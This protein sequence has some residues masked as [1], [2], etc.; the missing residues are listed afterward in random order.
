MKL[1]IS[2]LIALVVIGWSMKDDFTAAA[3]S[4]KNAPARIQCVL[5]GGK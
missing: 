1:A 4:I 2:V 5:D 3:N